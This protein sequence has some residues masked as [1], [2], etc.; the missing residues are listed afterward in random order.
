[1][2]EISVGRQRRCAHAAAVGSLPLPQGPCPHLRPVRPVLL[3][4][5]HPPRAR[6]CPRKGQSTKST[7]EHASAPVSWASLLAVFLQQQKGMGRCQGGTW[8][9]WHTA[10]QPRPPPIS[11]SDC[12]LSHIED[13]LSKLLP[14]LSLPSLFFLPRSELNRRSI[15]LWHRGGGRLPL[16]PPAVG[17]G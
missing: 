17:M 3:P 12:G 2:V 16:A 11:S 9:S 10:P 15:R 13:P 7:D 14:R 4:H 6:L 1:V 8:G 5:K